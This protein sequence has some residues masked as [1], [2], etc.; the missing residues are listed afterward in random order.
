MLSTITSPIVAPEP[1]ATP[2]AHR[3]TV[4]A[5]R[6][7]ALASYLNACHNV[8]VVPEPEL[9]VEHGQLTDYT[10]IDPAQDHLVIEAQ[11]EPGTLGNGDGTT[12]REPA[13]ASLV[14][15]GMLAVELTFRGD[16]MPTVVIENLH[17]DELLIVVE[18]GNDQRL[19]G[20]LIDPS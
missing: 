16:G 9:L 6:A 20:G 15:N 10:E 5:N 17:E 4:R 18:D 14:A 19:F 8:G 1:A 13:T 12:G 3:D 7:A 2:A 11:V